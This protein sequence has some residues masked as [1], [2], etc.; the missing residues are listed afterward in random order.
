[1]FRNVDATCRLLYHRESLMLG[2]RRDRTPAFFED[3]KRLMEKG[4][5]AVTSCKP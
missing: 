2:A 1:M 3:G 5:S 4:N